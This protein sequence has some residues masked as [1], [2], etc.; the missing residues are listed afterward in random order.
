MGNNYGGFKSRKSKSA[1]AAEGNSKSRT[2]TRKEYEKTY[3]QSWDTDFKSSDAYIEYK[4]GMLR[5]EMCIRP[6][7]EEI[8]HLRSLKTMGDIDRCVHS[9]IDRHWS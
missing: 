4:L 5:N 9:I 8:E 2:E 3:I 6:T 7:K 1:F